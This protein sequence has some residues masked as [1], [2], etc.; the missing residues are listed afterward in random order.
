MVVLGEPGA[1][2]TVLAVRFL[3]DQLRYRATL[4]DSVRADEPV[5][6]RVNAAGWDGSADFTAWMANQ[7]GIDYPLNP[8]VAPGNGRHR[9]DPSRP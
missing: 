7:L 3:R 5:P 1:G 2:K 8:R 6:V 9:P 4:A